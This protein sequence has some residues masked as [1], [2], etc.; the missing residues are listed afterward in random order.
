MASRMRM[1][2][3]IGSVKQ[4][5]GPNGQL[6]TEEVSLQAVYQENGVNKQW[7]KWTP[8][9]QFQFTI[10]NPEA[11]GKL[12]PGEYY[13]IDLVPAGKDEAGYAELE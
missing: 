11:M 6:E 1:K 10:S 4:V 13:F 9:I 12:R 5:I 7:C 2:A 3:Q 8:F